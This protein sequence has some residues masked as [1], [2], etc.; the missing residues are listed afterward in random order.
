MTLAVPASRTSVGIH[1]KTTGTGV[2]T[3][4]KPVTAVTFANG[5][6]KFAD[7]EVAGLFDFEQD[8]AFRVEQYHFDLGASVLYTISIVNLDADG[9]PIAGQ[10]LQIDT[11]TGQF[12]FTRTPFVLLVRQ[13]L[14]IVVAGAAVRTGQVVGLVVKQ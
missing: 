10:S 2:W 14:Q 6:N 1:Q 3:G 9:V 5:L 12:P 8:S 7:S 13:A 11:G 4:V